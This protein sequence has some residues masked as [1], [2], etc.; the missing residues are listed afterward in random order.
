MAIPP[1]ARRGISLR[2]P[3]H[4]RH[5]RESGDDGKMLGAADTN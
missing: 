4:H 2:D 1:A 3:Y 5:P